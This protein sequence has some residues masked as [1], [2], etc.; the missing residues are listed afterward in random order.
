MSAEILSMNSYS[1]NDKA[2]DIAIPV[3]AVEC[4]TTPPI[5]GHLDA[6]EDAVLKFVNI[7]LHKKEI[8]KALNATES[9]IEGI[10][11][12]LQE[13]EYLIKKKN[14]PWLISEHGEKYLKGEEE[15][16]RSSE[17]SQYGYMF[18]NAIKREVFPFFLI[19]DINQIP[20]CEGKP[21]PA[22]ITLDGDEKKTF[23]ETKIKNSKLREAYR[24]FYKLQEVRDDL[25]D[26]NISHEEAIE[27]V[28]DS[29]I[30]SDEDLCGNYNMPDEAE[31]D[32]DRIETLITSERKVSAQSQAGMI[33]RPLENSRKNVYLYM[34]LIIDPSVP[35]GYWVE[36][37]F[38]MGGIDNRYFLRQ[39]QWLATN[40]NTKI[41]EDSLQKFLEHEICKLSQTYKNSEKDFEV[42][43]LEKMPLLKSQRYKHG[44]MYDDMARIYSLIRNQQ[45]MMEKENIVS[46][47]SRSV[48]E[49]LYNGFFKQ[50][51]V[52]NRKMISKQALSDLKSMDV[53]AYI[54]MLLRNTKLNKENVN[55]S[56][57]YLSGAIGRLG[58]TKGNSTLEKFINI[59]VINYYIGTIET[60][61]LLNADNIN[62]IYTT[63]EELNRIRA[64]VSH[65]TDDRF[66][67]KDY[68]LF[69]SKVF[70]LISCLLEAYRE[71]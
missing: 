42:F 54:E 43:V 37:P 40:D 7:G 13:R 34:R 5:S 25:I 10:M 59:T 12:S 1:A 16:D 15:S 70:R 53:R 23:A 33:V 65:D 6:Y 55:W 30:L 67:I 62:E 47:I 35:G 48:L 69:M 27:F 56:G 45:S 24:R 21:L 44:N 68:E 63:T 64:K 36:S 17:C 58:K 4:E 51:D 71:E 11:V 66:E 22:R 49:C 31:K 41:G 38:R 50:I 2:I 19:G 57:G 20:L 39:V 14:C 3:I 28:E 18:I 46:N 32:E 60:R 61:K 52:R 8:A 29:D 26:N 9:L